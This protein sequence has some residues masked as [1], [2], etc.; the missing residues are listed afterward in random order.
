M[1]SRWK[2]AKERCNV[3]MFE[4]DDNQEIVFNA[5]KESL[6]KMG[7]VVELADVVE[8]TSRKESCTNQR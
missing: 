2:L 6:D 3:S 5:L 8:V 7:D 4:R 1:E